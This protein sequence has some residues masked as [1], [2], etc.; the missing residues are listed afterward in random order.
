MPVI[1][2]APV[3]R[4]AGK[5]QCVSV[6][7]GAMRNPFIK[8]SSPPSVAFGANMLRLRKVQAK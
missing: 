5:L 1:T 2:S 7:R 6:P 3:F 4:S 8:I